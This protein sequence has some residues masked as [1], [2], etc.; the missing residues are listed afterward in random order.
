MI[1]YQRGRL[2][3]FGKSGKEYKVP[4]VYDGLSPILDV[5]LLKGAENTGYQ[6]FVVDKDDTGSM[7]VFE[8]GSSEERWFKLR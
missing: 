6:L 3:A 1:L 7:A 4:Y 2:Q 8:K 5:E